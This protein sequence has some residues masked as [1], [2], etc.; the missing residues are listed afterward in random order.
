MRSLKQSV[1]ISLLATLLVALLGVLAG[2]GIG[3]LITLR[4]TETLLDH[5]AS[6]ALSDS[7]AFS[8][9]AHAV[10]DAMNSAANRDCSDADMD[11]LLKLFYK[12]H[13]MKDI[14][15]IRGNR[16]RC[17]T[18][19]GRLDA[20]PE[21]SQPSVV[22]ADGVQVFRDPPFYRI[23][24]TVVTALRDGDSY[25]VLNPF[26]NV[27]RGHAATHLKTTVL[28]AAQSETDPTP[29]RY[30]NV[31][32]PIL[33]R[34]AGFRMGDKLFE[35]RC[36]FRYNTCMTA[37]MTLAEAL[38]ANRVEFDGYILFGGIGGGV[39]GF[40]V[41][42]AYRRSRGMEHQLRRAIGRDE[43]RV[44]Y[45][46]ILD[47]ANGRV[48]GAEAL[49]RWT[50]DDGLSVGPDVF[51]K[52]AEDCGFV[53]DLTR[54]VIR[55]VLRDFGEVMRACPEFHVNVN[56]TA[57]DLADPF[58]PVRLQES[59]QRAGVQASCLGIEITE[60]CSAKQKEAIEAIRVLRGRGHKVYIDDFG[61]GY[62]SLSYLHNL[63]VD[64]IKIDKAFTRAIGTEAVTVGILP[65]ILAMAKTLNM[66]V[67]VEGI[68][69][70][71][72]ARF[73]SS[74]TM[75]M[76]VQGWFYGFPISTGDFHRLLEDERRNVPETT[77]V[78]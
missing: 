73:F 18:T 44:V 38:A 77:V 6:Q 53:G 68:E 45:Q 8:A 33:T 76:L 12:S 52:I 60:S 24:R 66:Q 56:V 17:S 65:Q 23:D 11:F 21:L 30:G 69:T 64:A 59:L 13:L 26:I 22:G 58:F 2:Y 28:V 40:L 16:I 9:D 51:V 25:V 15:R 42:L 1:A 29:R 70:K 34:N 27:L 72:Q 35:T 5:D 49:A 46:P 75:P 32:Q 3:V 78:L 48:V 31:S 74:S 10:L 63:S 37:S 47:Q 55:R 50:D 57:A 20:G 54:L 4:V 61:T 43:L 39:F 62:S 41:S 19:M 67:V 71:E 14:G 36:S 7:V